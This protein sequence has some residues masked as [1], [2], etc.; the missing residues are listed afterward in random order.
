MNPADRCRLASD[1]FMSF[2][3]GAS[4]EALTAAP[5]QVTPYVER[6]LEA[7]A[8]R[9]VNEGR[10]LIVLLTTWDLVTDKLAR[11]AEMREE[12]ERLLP[13]VKGATLLP[14]SGPTGRGLDQIRPVV[15][16]LY[17]DWAAKVKTRDLIN[18]LRD[19]FDMPGVPIRR[20]VKGGKDPYVKGG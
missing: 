12:F 8:D 15:L 2:M 13:K 17:R 19:A 18:G 5:P 3:S 10:G 7:L 6:L 1:R 14:I 4:P 20:I 11:L 9:M 16:E